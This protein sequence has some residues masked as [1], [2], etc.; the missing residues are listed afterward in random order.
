MSGP[1]DRQTEYTKWAA[2]RPGAP[3]T[4]ADRRRFRNPLQRPILAFLGLLAFAFV[5]GGGAYVMFGAGG[6]AL[7]ADHDAV[8]DTLDLQGGICCINHAEIDGKDYLFVAADEPRGR[9]IQQ[10][11]SMTLRVIEVTDDGMEQI[12]EIDA[13]LDSRL[14]WGMAIQ[15]SVVYVPVSSPDGEESG[16]WMLDVSEPGAPEEIGILETKNEVTQ[17]VA[18]GDDLISAHISGEFQF[19]D[20]SR[21]RDPE[22]IG[23][24]RQPVS[25]AQRMFVDLDFGRLY[26]REAQANRIRISDISDLEQATPLGRHFNEAGATRAQQ[27]IGSVIDDAAR[28][29]EHTAPASQFQ[30]FAVSGNVMY[31]AA[32]DR[33]LEV[34]DI[35][36]P[37]EPALVDRLDLTGHVVRVETAGNVLH[38]I[39]VEEHSSQ[40]LDYQV[41]RFDVGEPLEPKLLATVDNI[42]AAPGRQAIEAS[43]GYLFLGLSDTIVMIDASD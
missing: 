24:F 39:A 4:Q 27:R 35:S 15:D 23:T 33:G 37:V 29:L 38:A 32:S 30:D 21:S 22:L 14:A 36:D 16:I 3:G 26:D 1:Q 7:S 25:A 43:G 19:Y 41:H 8:V 20:V 18:S 2:S 5:V 12:E 10:S 17:L 28:R 34:A 42:Q 11:R 9:L 31:V 13:P 40:R 6:P